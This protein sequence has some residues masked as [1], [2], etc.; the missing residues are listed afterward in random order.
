MQIL[1]EFCEY[2]SN[3][4]TSV[5]TFDYM[6][7]L[8]LSIISLPEA[9][10]LRQLTVNVFGINCFGKQQ[11][12][13]YV[14]CNNYGGLNRNHT[15]KGYL[16]LWPRPTVLDQINESIFAATRTFF[17]TDDRNNIEYTAL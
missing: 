16:W 13:I 7:N 8:Q 14:S 12:R 2:P 10:Y 11:D 17:F 1:T 9:F 5:L 6:Q 4:S 15:V 3:T